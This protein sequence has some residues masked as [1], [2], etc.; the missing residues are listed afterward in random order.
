MLKVAKPFC[1]LS[2]PDD[3]LVVPTFN[4][5][6]PDCRDLVP[7]WTCVKA[8]FKLV[9]PEVIWPK[10]A[11]PF[12]NFWVP[13]YKEFEPFFKASPESNNFL[14]PAVIAEFDAVN[15]FSPAFICEPATA[16]FSAPLLSITAWAWTANF[17]TLGSELVFNLA[18]SVN[19]AAIWAFDLSTESIYLSTLPNKAVAPFTYEVAPLAKEEV[20]STYADKLVFKLSAPVFKLVIPSDKDLIPSEPLA[21]N[22]STPAFIWEIAVF[23]EEEPL[24]KVSTPE[25]T[26]LIPLSKDLLPS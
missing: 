26:W 8:D 7:F 22:S 14:A 11:E 2:L 10:E 25:F 17:C 16:N 4:V 23:N 1:K 18:N 3:N 9:I 24:L 6:T 20:P 12:A 13:A 19:K 5:P 21:D 15:F